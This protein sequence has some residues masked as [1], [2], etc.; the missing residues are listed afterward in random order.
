MVPM[1]RQMP[2]DDIRK[3]FPKIRDLAEIHTH[4]LKHLKD[5]ISPVSKT[6]LSTVFLDFREKFL[7]YGEYCSNLTG[8]IDTLRDI[9]KN[10]PAANDLV[11]QCQ[12]E[13]SGGRFHPL[14]D[15]LS[16]PMQR[17]LKYH[18]L[19]D[20]L[21][22]ETSP[23]HDDYRGLERA[24]EAMVDVA[25]FINEVKR[26]SEH[27][28]IIQKVNESIIDLNLQNGN[29]LQQ[30][31]HL[32]LDGELNVKAHEDQKQ[33]HRY[34]FIFEKLLILV[35]YSNSK[36][37]EGQ[38][39]FRDAHDLSS[40]TIGVLHSR[41]TLGRDGRFKYQLLLAKKT[42]ESAFTLY[43]KTEAERLKWHKAF[44]EAMDN[45]EPQGCRS[46]DHQFVLTTF[47]T[48]KPCTHCSKFLKG[49]IHQGYKCRVCGISVHKGCI[50]S[51]GHCRPPS[52][53]NPPPVCDRQ[54]TAF[55][56]F[57]G[58]MDR[59]TAFENLETRKVG[60]YLLRVRPNVGFNQ[61]ETMYALSLKYGRYF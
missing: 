2:A 45:L 36:I 50:S 11:Q 54:L 22:H 61:A 52:V 4:F 59:D 7:I 23:T 28:V 15:I 13:H 26:D 19:L 9:C 10:S 17:I 56:W 31:G 3:I 18:L 57:V 33:K 1:E 47:D 32:L 27:L 25:Q 49:L 12:K 53:G 42:Q 24:K 5:A 46:T 48:S 29:D 8:A 55:N 60:T 14:R 21:V 51:T 43:L 6:K 37:G 34:A 30:Y 38:Y 58:C 41:K 40:Y 20:K 39:S 16:V 35:K 44:L